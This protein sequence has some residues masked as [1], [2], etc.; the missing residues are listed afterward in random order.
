[1]CEGGGG[2]TSARSMLCALCF[3]VCSA[4]EQFI[5][6][7]YVRK[8]WMAKDAGTAGRQSKPKVS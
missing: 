1:M 8:T 2:S 6:S 3:S 5:R 7:K 4:A